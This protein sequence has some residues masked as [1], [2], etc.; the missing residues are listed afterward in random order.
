MHNIS[1]KGDIIKM[2][3]DLYL[4]PYDSLRYPFN[5]EV[6]GYTEDNAYTPHIDQRENCYTYICEYIVKGSGFLTCNGHNYYPQAGDCYILPKHSKHIYGPNPQDPWTKI[7]F[8]FDGPLVPHM[9]NGFGLNNE[10]F[11]SSFGHEN[12]FV[13]MFETAKNYSDLEHLNF[14][15]SMKFYKLLMLLNQH[16]TT[17][18]KKDP[19]ERIQFIIDS[20][21]YEQLD[22][23]YVSKKIFLSKTHIINLFQQKF[24]ITPYQYYIQQKISLAANYLA[25]SKYSISDISKILSFTDHQYFCRFFQK[26]YRNDSAEI[27]QSMG[28]DDSRTCT[29]N[30]TQFRLCK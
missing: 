6:C 5:L 27:S 8:L 10:V 16:L 30:Y 14:E 11:F 3:E 26:A 19:A 24:G 23:D 13:E 2:K 7:W 21:I 29:G 9:I 22:L 4:F 15:M 18:T 20:H 25:N 12:I 28:I 1:Q 17:H